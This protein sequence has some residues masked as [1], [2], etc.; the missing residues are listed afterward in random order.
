MKSAWLR[1]LSHYVGENDLN[2]FM[3]ER[4]TLAT[5]ALQEQRERKVHMPK[6]LIS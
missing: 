6:A 3:K 4:L 1:N 2:I 5:P